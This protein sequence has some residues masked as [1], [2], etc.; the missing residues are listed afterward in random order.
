MNSAVPSPSPGEVL[1]VCPDEKKLG[2]FAEILSKVGV[3]VLMAQSVEDG[4]E[5]LRNG[6]IHTAVLDLTA[7][8]LA[9]PMLL[10][11]ARSSQRTA[12]IPF[13][14]LTRN[15]QP[16]PNL[17]ALGDE[18]VQDGFLVLPC[19]SQQFTNKVLVVMDMADRLRATRA[20][21]AASATVSTAAIAAV[22]ALKSSA[23]LQAAGQPKSSPKAAAAVSSMFAGML[24]ALDVLKILSM[25]EPLRLTGELTI[26]DD[27]RTGKIFFVEGAVWHASMNEMSGPDALF[28]LF[29]MKEG[30]FRFDPGEPV[31]DRTIQGNTMGLLLEG[32]RQMD[33]AKTIIKRLQNRRSGQPVDEEGPSISS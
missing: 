1:I 27:K 17:A 18:T 7:P 4:W 6:V 32:M 26:T 28:L 13:L 30:A 3:A 16:L 31:I 10:R 22:R 15:D 33:E 8:G 24:G 20:A 12:G 9:A 21:K 2:L 11:A 19:S 25:L 14:Y 5:V 23:V 29:H